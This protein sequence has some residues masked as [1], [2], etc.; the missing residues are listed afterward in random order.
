[1]QDL[2]KKSILLLLSVLSLAQ[3]SRPYLQNLPLTEQEI[4]KDERNHHCI[5]TTK[6]T[7]VERMNF[8]PFNTSAVIK[9][10]SFNDPESQ[11]ED[12]LPMKGNEIDY[13]KITEE[14]TLSKEQIDELTSIL[15]NVTYQGERYLEQAERVVIIPRMQFCSVIKTITCWSSSKY[16]FTAVGTN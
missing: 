12:T 13:T 6:Y 3:C 16:A 10:V 2:M 11:I 8:F 5:T 14:E 7:A 15:Y 1:M 4:E 9:I